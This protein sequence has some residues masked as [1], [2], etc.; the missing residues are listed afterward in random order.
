MRSGNL[1]V[2]VGAARQRRLTRFSCSLASGWVG[3]WGQKRAFLSG[4]GIICLKYT[5]SCFA[6]SDLFRCVLTGVNLTVWSLYTKQAKSSDIQSCS[7]VKKQFYL[8]VKHIFP[9]GGWATNKSYREQQD[10]FC[11]LLS[12]LC[13]WFQVYDLLTHTCNAYLCLTSHEGSGPCCVLWFHLL[14][15]VIMT[16]FSW[17]KIIIKLFPSIIVSWPSCSPLFSVTHLLLDTFGYEMNK[18][19]VTN[20]CELNIGYPRPT[21]WMWG[22]IHAESCSQ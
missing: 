6:F 14:N 18:S 10:I 16:S 12:C 22:W 3:G 13:I 7:I 20:D 4:W 8:K 15:A 2:C 17:K 21:V 19:G 5:L 11:T 1:G 9:Q